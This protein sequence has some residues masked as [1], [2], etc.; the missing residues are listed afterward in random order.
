MR[1]AQVV[2]PFRAP[3]S[4]LETVVARLA[5]VASAREAFDRDNNWASALGQAAEDLGP[6]FASFAAYLATRVDLLAVSDCRELAR[7]R[8]RARWPVERIA[9]TIAAELSDAGAIVDL[10]A[11]PVA[12][13]S[14]SQTHRARLRSRERVHVAVVTLDDDA[15]DADLDLLAHVRHACGGVLPDLVVD[16]A[17][18]D[19]RNRFN[20]WRDCRRRLPMTLEA[21]ERM[22]SGA[23][24]V[25]ARPRL[26]LC[27]RHV[28]VSDDPLDS[29]EMPAD[30]ASPWERPADRALELISTWLRQAVSGAVFPVP[31]AGDVVGPGGRLVATGT[32]A[33]LPAATGSHMV[34]YLLALVGDLP[35]R[36]WAALALE[37]TPLRNAAPQA[38]VARA[39]RCLVPFRDDRS[40]D[41][42]S[43]VADHAF[44]QWRAATKHGW[45]PSPD[46][47]PF[48]QGLFAVVTAVRDRAPGRDLLAEAARGLRFEAGVRQFDEW[49]RGI[50]VMNA[51]ERQMMLMLQLPQK[52]DQL[53]TI[54]A[55]G[56]VRVQL[57]TAEDRGAGR[58]S[59]AAAVASILLVAAAVAL[60]AGAA[61]PWPPGVWDSAPSLGLLVAGGLLVWAVGRAL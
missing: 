49:T 40:C 58:R 7:V 23:P 47:V 28:F 8:T 50:D 43:D 54:A 52:L 56:A 13:T 46:L 4:R 37:L 1:A 39:F 33:R 59:R 45:L 20:L 31:A 48:Y 51:M 16:A 61:V 25:V 17:I 2:V 35:D 26:D 44:L 41:S 12:V 18:A 34:T 15:A 11:E 32:L 10:A 42:G 19:F 27:S 5:P 55:D 6:V 38:E 57:V 24:V 14:F 36:S 30:V 21:A 60:L 22:E 29:A 3:R 9:R 53:L